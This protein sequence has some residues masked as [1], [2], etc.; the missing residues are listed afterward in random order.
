MSLCITQ[1]VTLCKEQG[2]KTVHLGDRMI[3]LARARFD[4]HL[5]CFTPD[6]AIE[7]SSFIRFAD[8]AEAISFA[9]S[10]GYA[11]KCVQKFGNRRK[12]I[13]WAIREGASSL[14]FVARHN[15]LPAPAGAHATPVK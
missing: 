4:R 9:R 6:A 13:Q 1:T 8:K 11:A 5:H 7:L 15:L 2:I 3:Q 14:Y 10:L 12:N